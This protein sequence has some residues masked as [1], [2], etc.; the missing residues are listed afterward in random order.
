[1][2]IYSTLIEKVENGTPF[3]VDF[4]T[5]TLRVGKKKLIDNGK[6]EGDLFDEQTDFLETVTS[7]YDEYKLSTPS[8]KN[9]R[10]YFYAVPAKEMTWEQLTVGI[11]R[12]IAMARLEGYILCKILEGTTWE[13]ITNNNPRCTWFWRKDDLVLF[14]EWF[15]ETKGE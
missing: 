8:S 10:S 11:P 12:E 15:D 1:M 6:Y 3:K 7:L 5:R 14:K 4:K 9:R 2:S 13:S